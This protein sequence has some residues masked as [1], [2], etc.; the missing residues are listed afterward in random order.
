MVPINRIYIKYA[1]FFL[2][3]HSL[4]NS[5]YSDECI[6]FNS[7][8]PGKII[9][10]PQCTLSLEST[11]KDIKKIELQARYF[12]LF[13]DTAN[14]VNIGTLD[15]PPYQFVWDISSLPNQLFAGVAFLAEVYHK[16]GNIYDIRREGVF[17]AHQA[18]IYKRKTIVYDFPGSRKLSS[19]TIIIPGNRDNLSIKSSIYWNE[20]NLTFLIAV[21]D[22]FFHSNL[23]KSALS[24]ICVEIM[25]DPSISRKPYPSKEVVAFNIPLYGIPYIINYKPAFDET[26]TFKLISNSSTCDFPYSIFKEDYKGYEILFPIPK[27]IFGGVIPD[28]LTCNIALKV[29]DKNNRL[30]TVSWVRTN[31]YDIHSPFVWN[32]IVRLPKPFYKNRIL[33]FSA[34]FIAGLIFITLIWI[35]ISYARK[36]KLKKAIEKTE[37]EQKLFDNLKEAID[38]QITYKNITN[39]IVAKELHI[40]PKKLNNLVKRLTGYSFHNYLMLARIEIA[41]E[42]L[43]SSFCNESTIADACGFKDE[44][45]LEKYFLKFEHTSPAKYREKQQVT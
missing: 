35:I 14:I 3:I 16:N 43:R 41:K 38:R 8:K 45:E 42:R 29:M 40:S 36:P 27:K 11:C 33:I 1:V 24:D 28:S 13:S 30:K 32:T 5:V 19:D 26:G 10:T 37:A 9:T 4:F 6:L 2:L 31:Q 20:K 44:A 12:S 39:E 23:P 17:F 22:P 21:D 18:I 15:K 7:P 34:G 25:L